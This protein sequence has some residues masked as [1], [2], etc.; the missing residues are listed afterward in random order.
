MK[1]HLPTLTLAALVAS[2]ITP[3]IVSADNGQRPDQPRNFDSMDV[4]GDDQLSREEISALPEPKGAS[5]DAIFDRIDSNNDDYISHEEMQARQR[6]REEVRQRP[7]NREN[8]TGGKGKPPSFGELDQNED[9]LLSSAELGEMA[10]RRGG[11][12]EQMPE[13]MDTDGDGQVSE[14]EIQ[15]MRA[16]RGGHGRP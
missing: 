3:I 6:S 7:G 9:G 8:G 15:A 11:S 13:R 10:A 5:H 2:A 16:N 14:A 12:G 4:N 1:N